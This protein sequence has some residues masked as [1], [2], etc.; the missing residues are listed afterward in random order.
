M[1]L[2]FLDESGYTFDWESGI[3]EQPWY[4]LS[5]ITLP[6]NAIGKSYSILRSAIHDIDIPGQDLEIGQGYE[7]KAKDIAKGSG[8]WSNH[9]H[10]RN[11]VRKKMLSFPNKC[12]GSAFV[13]AVDKEAHFRKY[14]YPDNPYLLAL[15][16]I[17]E[18]LEIHLSQLNEDAICIY[19]RNTRLENDIQDK[20]SNLKEVG[21]HIEYFSTELSEYISS[22]LNIY[23]ILEVHFG[24]SLHSIGLQIAD[25]FATMTYTYLKDGKPDPCG[26]WDILCSSLA[27]KDGEIQ[28]IGLKIFP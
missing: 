19:D 13:L 8:W 2:V 28:G 24:D 10:E 12:G 26:W 22:T 21:S 15:K 23:R 16:F 6:T 14:T 1:Q 11:I 4:V 27:K 20:F 17:I 7:I 3:Y 9:N 5:A 18:R 25:Y